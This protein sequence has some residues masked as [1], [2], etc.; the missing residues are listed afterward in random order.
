M[1]YIEPKWLIPE[2]KQQIEA[3]GVDDNGV[4]VKIIIPKD[5]NNSDYNSL[6][7]QYTIEQIDKNTAESVRIFREMQNR[8]SQRNLEEKGRQASE[9]LFLAKLEAFEMDEVKNTTNKEFKRSIRKSKNKTEVLINTIVGII[10]E[11][12]K[13]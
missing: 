3:T 12:N 7:T 8:M 9:E 2:D 5:N 13:K 4:Q 10:N 1:K 11:R 6:M